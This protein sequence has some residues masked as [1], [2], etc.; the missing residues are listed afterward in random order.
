M[1]YL[2]IFLLTLSICWA[3]QPTSKEAT[4]EKIFSSLTPEEF[5]KALEQAK[6]AGVPTQV[7]LEARFLNLVDQKNYH[8]IAQLTPELLKQ[9]DQF[10]AD[11]SEIF[12]VK[13]DWLAI[14]HY[15]QALD[16]LEKNDKVSFK[17]HIT[18][19]FW[20]SP[21]QGRAFAPH[22]NNL[23]MKEAMAKITLPP[24]LP[25]LPQNGNQNTT[26]GKLMK[27]KKG[28]VLY[29]WS[30]MSQEVFQDLE[31]FIQLSQACQKHEIAVISILVG[32]NNDILED[33]K[34][35]SQE[36][37]KEAKSAWMLD[38]KKQA[39]SNILRIMD[40]PNIVLVS[41]KGS[42]LFNGH[43]SQNNFWKQLQKLDPTFKPLNRKNTPHQGHAHADG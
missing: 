35:W 26:L 39:L 15:A 20:L 23:R 27:N 34:L 41:P 10:N 33:A 4:I 3:D 24:D 18:E 31:N 28:A 40:I 37:A 29:F 8:A 42:I 6:N 12:A 1:K 19:A 22:I 25:M 16:A 36:D 7:L 5:S 17:K 21:R 43:P 30:P 13:E 2:F 11:T 14:I 9:R 32:Y 38:P